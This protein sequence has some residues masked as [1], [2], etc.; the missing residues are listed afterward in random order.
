MA[1]I[2]PVSVGRDGSG[3]V[4]RTQTAQGTT[5][6]TDWIQVPDWARYATVEYNLTSVGASTTPTVDLTLLAPSITAPLDDAVTFNLNTG[7]TAFTQITAAASLLITIGPDVLYDATTAASGA[8]GA[9]INA[10]L[11]PVL[12]IKLLQDRGTGDEVYTYTLA[13]R[14]RGGA[15][16]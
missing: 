13:I 9:S 4:I 1:V 3:G 14:F 2:T 5:G 11:P 12:G 8:S 16:H 10:V 7:G 6:Q 15:Y